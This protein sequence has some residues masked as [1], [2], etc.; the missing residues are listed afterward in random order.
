MTTSTH[1]G[2]RA[3]GRA[4]Q[5]RLAL[6]GPRIIALAAV[7]IAVPCAALLLT[8]APFEQ[9]VRACLRLTVA[10][11]ALLLIAVFPASALKRHWP[12]RF[13]RW[14]LRNRR[15]LGLSVAVSQLGF[16]GTFIA[17]L[18]A[19]GAGGETSLVTVVGGGFGLVCLAAM[20]TTSTDAAQRRLGARWRRLHLFCLYG[21]WAI[22]TA[23]YFLMALE[24]RAIA[25]AVSVGLIGGLMLRLTPARASAGGA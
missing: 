7:L 17:I 12:G 24:G 15:Y 2:A 14:L 4:P 3:E 11:S 8:V 13:P 9:A 6:E 21:T 18:Y 19:M 5:H 1:H 25:I 23:S 20:A 10:T 22:F 16:H